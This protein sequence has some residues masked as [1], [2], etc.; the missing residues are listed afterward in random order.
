MEMDF[1]SAHHITDPK[2]NPVIIICHAIMCG[3]Y[4][5]KDSIFLL[6]PPAVVWK[7]VLDHN[8][9]DIPNL[10]VNDHRDNC[11]LCILLPKTSEASVTSA[12]SERHMPKHV[13]TVAYW[14]Q[15]DDGFWTFLP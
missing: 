6:L 7:K 10:E 2:P 14:Q 5:P 8:A 3:S 11:Y 15:H 13:L 12:N 4:L 1:I 9:K